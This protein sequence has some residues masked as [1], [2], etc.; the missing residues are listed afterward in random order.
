MVTFL[1]FV[2][3]L[4]VAF[5]ISKVAAP[6]FHGFLMTLLLMPFWVSEMVRVY[7]WMI[8]LRESGVVNHLLEASVF[9]IDR[10]KCSTMMSP[11]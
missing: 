1:T 6:K 5:Y 2:V 10:W 9:S 11:W 3:T 7:G 8:L 4:P